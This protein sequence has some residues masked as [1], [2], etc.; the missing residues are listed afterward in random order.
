M[1]C[2]CCGFSSHLTPRS[3]GHVRVVTLWERQREDSW[4][5]P[6]HLVQPCRLQPSHPKAGLGPSPC[7]H[8]P[9]FPV[10]TE[11]AVL[12]HHCPPSMPLHTH[13]GFVSATTSNSA[14]RGGA[15]IVSLQGRARVHV[16]ASKDLEGPRVPEVGIVPIPSPSPG[17]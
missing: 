9:S 16:G 13:L 17:T 11:G 10:G 14:P 1:N 3:P 4:F 8:P 7:Q 6:R 15:G 12:S 5:P 2:S